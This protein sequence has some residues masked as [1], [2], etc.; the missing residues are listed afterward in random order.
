M[1]CDKYIFIFLCDNGPC[2]PGRDRGCI[3]CF[4]GRDGEGGVNEPC[5]SQEGM[6]VY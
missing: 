2:F 5:V 1:G 6:G 3:R 4:P